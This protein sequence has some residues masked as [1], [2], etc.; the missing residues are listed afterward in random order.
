VAHTLQSQGVQTL[1]LTVRREAT[2]AIITLSERKEYTVKQFGFLML[3]Q[4]ITEA[5]CEVCVLDVGGTLPLVSEDIFIGVRTLLEDKAFSNVNIMGIFSGY[6]EETITGKQCL[7]TMPTQRLVMW[8]WTAEEVDALS[9]RMP[10]GIEEGA[11]AVCGGSVRHLFEVKTDQDV[12]LRAVK[13]MDE[14]Q[15]RAFAWLD[16]PTTDEGHRQRKHL[17]SFVPERDGSDFKQGTVAACR[18]PRSDYVIQCISENRYAKMEDVAIM[19][20]KLSAIRSGAAGTIF[21]LMVHM[22]WREKVKDNAKVELRLIQILPTDEDGPE[23]DLIVDC[24]KLTEVVD[25]I[26][27]WDD[28]E[29]ELPLGYYTHKNARYPVLD[30]IL[31]FR[32]H[33]DTLRVLPIQVSIAAKHVHGDYKHKLLDTEPKQLALWDYRLGGKTCQWSPSTSGYWQLC[34]VECKEFNKVVRRWQD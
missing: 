28:K 24:S 32:T 6:G 25:N 29:G 13:G 5:K 12:I 27:E 14:T 31:R 7:S 22:F 9:K 11:F 3:Y 21:K 33:E 23:E 10:G 1:H 2:V 15:M 34:R 8:S 17:L 18:V 30:S 26:E 4:A 16:A 19:Y 20:G